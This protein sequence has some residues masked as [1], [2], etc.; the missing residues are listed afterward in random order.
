MKAI[1]LYE[2]LKEYTEEELKQLDLVIE[3][4]RKYNNILGEGFNVD[5]IN[6][7]SSH[8]RLINMANTK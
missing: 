6:E 5:K 1:K 7:F 2:V 3:I 8:I 4:G